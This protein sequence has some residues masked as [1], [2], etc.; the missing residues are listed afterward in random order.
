MEY[1]HGEDLASSCRAPRPGARVPFEAAL[2]IVMARRAGLDHAHR[3]CDADGKPLRLVHR[4]VSPSNI[5]VG[6]DGAVK[7]VDFGIAT[8]AMQTVHTRPAW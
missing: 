6:H 7:L 3:R 8:A 4:D 5:M 1:V 2:A